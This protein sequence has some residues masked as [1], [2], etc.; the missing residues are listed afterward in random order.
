MECH[1][2]PHHQDIEAR[3]YAGVAFKCTPC[4]NCRLKE[5]SYFT[6]EFLPWIKDGQDLKDRIIAAVPALKKAEKRARTR[7]MPY[8]ILA[9][10]ADLFLSLQP[11]D[12]DCVYWRMHGLSSDDIG[13]R[14]GITG[15]S[16]QRR[17]RKVI[18]SHPQ[19]AVAIGGK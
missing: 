15:D 5:S 19:I 4:A 16:V 18:L 9:A 1:K 7:M 11:A 17:L 6:K 2:C 14:M 3:K 13:R 12:R 8:A 10:I